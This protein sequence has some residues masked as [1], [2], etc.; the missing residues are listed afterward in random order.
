VRKVLRVRRMLHRLAREV[1][2]VL[3]PERCAACSSLVAART[4]FCHACRDAVNALG[5][6]ECTRCGRPLAVGTC[7]GCCAVDDDSPVRHARAFARYETGVARH[8]I[9]AALH[10]FKYRGAWR[11]APRL[12][13]AMSA[14][15]PVAPAATLVVPVPLHV[16]RLRA[17]GF[18]QSALLAAEVARALGRP[19]ACDF[20]VRRRDTPSQTALA[21]GDRRANVAEA[22]AVRRPSSARD[23]HVLLVDDVWTSGATARAA[24]LALRADGARA[25]DVLTFA[26][27][28]DARYES[29]V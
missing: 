16:T 2:D 21:A 27:V 19:V 6:P 29:G 13:L 24:A 20:L 15:A 26:R 7:C 1:A 10:A 11:L 4:L 3:C 23:R 28:A 14:R 17:R 18:N 22:F 5:P 25:V 12:A 8:P 9:S